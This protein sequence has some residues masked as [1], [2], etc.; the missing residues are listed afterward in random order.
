LTQENPELMSHD[1][2][3][4]PALPTAAT[5]AI[6][7]RDFETEGPMAV[8]GSSSASS[9]L[10]PP[11]SPATGR[12]ASPS[13]FPAEKDVGIEGFPAEKDVGIEGF[14]AVEE[15]LGIT[16]TQFGDRRQH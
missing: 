13:V 3:G 1:L 9:P 6:M 5:G 7:F 12:S 8:T 14:P 16:Q 2:A 15:Q 11:S 10:G 4:A